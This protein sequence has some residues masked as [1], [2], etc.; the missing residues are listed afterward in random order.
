[1]YKKHNQTAEQ[2]H[3]DHFVMQKTNSFAHLV[4][5]LN[6]DMGSVSTD[7]ADLSCH[8]INAILCGASLEPI[9]GPELCSLVIPVISS[10][11]EENLF[12]ATGVILKK[13]PFSF[14]IA[15]EI[16]GTEL[17]LESESFI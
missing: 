10:A 3:A 4:S 5:S 15:G 13:K 16:A 8:C 12:F 11:I 1:M 14:Q 17:Q 9:C 2:T 7:L 6:Q